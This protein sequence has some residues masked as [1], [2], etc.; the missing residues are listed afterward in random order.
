[1]LSVGHTFKAQACIDWIEL[2]FDFGHPTQFQWVQDALRKVLDLPAHS[3]DLYVTALNP[4]PGNA[5]TSFAIKFYD[6]QANSYSELRRVTTKLC[7]LY[8]GQF[9]H[10]KV[11]GLE[12]A[13]DFYARDSSNDLIGLTKR[14]Q[15]SL[16]ARGNPRQYSPILRNRH[17]ETDVNF[18]IDPQQNLRVGNVRDPVSWQV[19]YKTTDATHLTV[20]RYCARAEVTIL[21]CALAE[22]GID[23]LAGLEEFRFE[24]LA[25]LL[26]FRR[27]KSIDQICEGQS[28]HFVYAA[29]HHGDPLTVPLCSY[30]FGWHSYKADSRDGSPRNRGLPVPLKHN[31]HSV[32]DDDLNRQVRKKFAA[33][34]KRFSAKDRD[35]I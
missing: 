31:R 23:T 20:E 11:V 6:D 16:S 18:L 8:Q 33:F 29:R 24:R 30:P 14:M 25:K 19:Y 12:F 10:V 7:E 3:K 2:C 21:G 35:R 32:A 13:L 5:S 17:L 15:H 4:G 1:M 27:L 9:E 22:N 26:H 34:T 28:E